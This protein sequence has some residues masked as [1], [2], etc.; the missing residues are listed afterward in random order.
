MPS[1]SPS[2]RPAWTTARLAFALAV[3]ATLADQVAAAFECGPN[4]HPGDC[5][6]LHDL[7]VEAGG[8]GWLNQFGFGSGVSFCRWNNSPG[9]FGQ[10]RGRALHAHVRPRP[11]PPARRSPRRPGSS[12]RPASPRPASPRPASTSGTVADA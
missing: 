2:P 11:G 12:A 9:N 3:A 10:G 5:Q 1:P 4:D 6:A 8:E 7:Y